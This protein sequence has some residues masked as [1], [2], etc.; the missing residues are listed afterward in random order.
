MHPAVQTLRN[1][2]RVEHVIFATLL[3]AIVLRFAFL[4][5][6]LFHHDEASHAWISY[7]LLTTGNYLYDPMFHGPFLYYITASMFAVFGDADF[8]GR[9]LPAIAGCALIPLVYWLYRLRYL[10]GK[11]AAASAL[12][13]AVA[14]ELVYFSRFLRNDIFVVFFSLL[15]VAAFLAWLDKSKWYY[16]ALAAAAGALGMCSKENMPLILV[17]FAIFF[18]YLL[19]TRKITLPE[20]WIRDL[21]IAAVI[22]FGIIFTMYSSFWTHPEM[23]LQAGPL[24]IEHWLAMH[25]EQRI[26]GPPVFYL[27]MFILYELPILLLAL[28]GVVLFLVTGKK[29]PSAKDEEQEQEKQEHDDPE[30]K[31]TKKTFSFVSLFRRPAVPASIDKKTEF[32]RFAVYWTLIACLTYAY[33]GEKVPWLSLHQL[34]PMIFVAAFAL[35]F[36]GKYW[37]IL[38]A[39]CAVLLFAMTCYVAYTPADIAEPII[40]VQ[41]SEDLVPLMAAIDASE[42][43]ALATDQEWPFRWYYRGWDIVSYCEGKKDAS[44]LL[45]G[46]FDII[47]TH[48]DESYDSLA[49]Y[50]KET[51][52][53]N[54]W[55]DHSGTGEDPGWIPYYF[56]RAGKIGSYNFDIFTRSPV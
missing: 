21:I 50:T 42:R 14:P 44:T 31:E 8:V 39:V 36:T 52:R 40:Q 15:L 45:S 56:T 28:A 7:Q 9:I 48:D 23:I 20:K 18:L 10:T 30:Q 3:L 49:G 19:W 51:I 47:I 11:V 43:V 35:T 13:L 46:N 5:L 16:L 12:F 33:I 1:H 32:M 37:K 29:R 53:L 17:T 4:D 41:N 25:N 6:K 24:A 54:Y 22:F 55:F 26:A 2:I 27:L 38:L 34:V